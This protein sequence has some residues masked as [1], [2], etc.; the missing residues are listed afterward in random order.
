MTAVGECHAGVRVAVGNPIRAQ[1]GSPFVVSQPAAQTLNAAPTPSSGTR[2]FVK[3]SI[4]DRQVADWRW[5]SGRLRRH[6]GVVKVAFV[7]EARDGSDIR[8]EGGCLQD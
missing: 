7:S 4:P 2:S 3:P 6:A 5:E 8:A 1:G